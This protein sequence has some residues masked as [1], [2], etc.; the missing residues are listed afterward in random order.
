M[1][2]FAYLT[3]WL[4]LEDRPRVEDRGTRARLR[5]LVPPAVLSGGVLGGCVGFKGGKGVNASKLPLKPRK[6]FQAGG[7]LLW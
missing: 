7:Q 5:V 4:V 2:L 1:C 3:Y 6:D